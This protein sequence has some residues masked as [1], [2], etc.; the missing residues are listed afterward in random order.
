ML[1]DT[2]LMRSPAVICRDIL[3]AAYQT[4]KVLGDFIRQQRDHSFNI[5][6]LAHDTVR[7][8]F[9]S[10]PLRIHPTLCNSIML[11]ANAFT[12]MFTI[13]SIILNAAV[14]EVAFI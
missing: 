3:E 5:L 12:I 2:L 11:T 14:M 7:A 6:Y 9:G 8:C 13:S 10:F 4:R 1:L